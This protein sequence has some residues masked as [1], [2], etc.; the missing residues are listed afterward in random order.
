MVFCG[1]IFLLGDSFMGKVS[2]E[3]INMMKIVCGWDW[4]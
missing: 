2:I 1:N 3:V 4:R